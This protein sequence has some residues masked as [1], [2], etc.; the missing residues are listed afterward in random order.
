MLSE[1][2]T[3]ARPQGAGGVRADLSP[4]ANQYG[5]MKA[6]D[7]KRLKELERENSPA[8]ADGRRQGAGKPGFE[9]DR[10]G[11]LLSPSRRR[12]AVLHACRTASASPSVGRAGSPASTAPRSA[13]HAGRPRDQALRGGCA[14]SLD[15]RPR[16]GYRRAHAHLLE[17]GMAVNRKRV[18]RIWREEGLRVP[19]RATKR[20][21]LGDSTVPRRPAPGGAPQPRLGA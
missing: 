1:G 19:A 15:E 13:T 2:K 7:V 20:R 21:R 11:K 9:G 10:Q 4:L 14:R 16:W 5:G 8:Q 18:Q 6:D 12:Q 17:R 3:I